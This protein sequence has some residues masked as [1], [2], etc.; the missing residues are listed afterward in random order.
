MYDIVGDARQLLEELDQKVMSNSAYDTAWVARVTDGNGHSAPVFPEAMEWL[1]QNQYPDGS[2][3]GQIRYYHDRIIS[4]LAAIIALVEC[5]DRSKDAKAIQRGESYIHQNVGSL[6]QDP[7]ETVGFEL[8]LPTLLDKARQLGLNLPYTRCARYSHIREAKLRKIPQ[9]LLCSRRVTT[10]HSLEFMG[11]KLEMDRSADLQEENGSFGNSPAATAY[12]LSKGYESPAARQYLAETIQIGGGAAMPAYPTEIFVRSWVLYNLDLAGLLDELEDEARAHL[13]HLYLAWDPEQGVGFSRVYSVPDLDDTAV[14]FKLLCR[15]G[16]EVDPDVFGVY[17]RDDHFVCY[18]YERNP[19]IGAHVHLLDA[20]QACP[21]Y[22]R[23]PGM[24]AKALDFYRNQLYDAYWFDKWHISPYYML[25][26]AIIATVGCDDELAREA[27]SW[28]V[29]TQREDGTWG[30][31]GSTAEETAYCLQALILYHREVDPLEPAVLY[32]PAQYLYR[33]YL[34]QNHP[35]MWIE[36]CLYTPPQ[37]VRSAM[38]SA[39]RMYETL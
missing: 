17:E 26:H 18:A 14:V 32:H 21:E 37:I 5:G 24:L 15:A 30:Y 27:V 33:Q 38:L 16:Y 7:C 25:S 12:V 6:H 34:S 35:A 22:G 19:S 4:T 20:L 8:I 2:W 13:D 28:I 39:L 29:D 31:F 3:G 9:Q 1:R 10:T 23:Q 36:K 11:D